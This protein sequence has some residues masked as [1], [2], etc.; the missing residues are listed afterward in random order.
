MS[1]EPRRTG[2]ALL[3]LVEVMDPLA[4]DATSGG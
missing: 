4:E 2:E 1:D 3:E